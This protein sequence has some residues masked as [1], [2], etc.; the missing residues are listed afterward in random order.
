[1]LPGYRL[2]NKVLSQTQIVGSKLKRH[3]SS[4][5]IMQLKKKTAPMTL[6]FCVNHLSLLNHGADFNT[7]Q[8]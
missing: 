8:G 7:C 5:T 2:E 1:M 4:D 3:F 6:F